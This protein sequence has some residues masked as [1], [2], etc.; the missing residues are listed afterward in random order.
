MK[1][2]TKY[3]IGRLKIRREELLTFEKLFS[4]KSQFILL[5]LFLNDFYI[6]NNYESEI[7]HRIFNTYELSKLFNYDYDDR[8]LS[9]VEFI[10]YVVTNRSELI[11][12]YVYPDQVDSNS[13]N[14]NLGCI[15]FVNIG[16]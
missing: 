10:K 15:K 8:I 16:R 4:M 9:G 6:Q 1:Y 14:V 13:F 7:I 11:I 2:K 3:D 12:D 5:Y